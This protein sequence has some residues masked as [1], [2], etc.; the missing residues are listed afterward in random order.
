MPGLVDRLAVPLRFVGLAI[1]SA[2]NRAM[3]YGGLLWVSPGIGYIY[4]AAG[5]PIWRSQPVERDP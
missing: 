4:R 5:F 3:G 1:G 2:R